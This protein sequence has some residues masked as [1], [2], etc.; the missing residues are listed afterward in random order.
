MGCNDTLSTLFALGS[1]ESWQDR[2][3]RAINCSG[4]VGVLEE[5]DDEEADF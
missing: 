5:D 4:V 2:L 3:G 1:E